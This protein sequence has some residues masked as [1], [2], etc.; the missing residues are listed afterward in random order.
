MEWSWA[1]APFGFTSRLQAK[2]FT[3]LGIRTKHEQSKFAH[4][5]RRFGWA[6]RPRRH[7]A[8]TRPAGD[9]DLRRRN[10]REVIPFP[11][12]NRG[13]DLMTKSPAKSIRWASCGTLGIKLAKDEKL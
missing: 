10:H 2:I 11:K 1:A 3:V 8:R 12:N 6:R 7:R 5:L 4:L 13:I 9:A